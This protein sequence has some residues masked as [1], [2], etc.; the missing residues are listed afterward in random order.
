MSAT[1]FF[2]GL[3]HSCFAPKTWWTRAIHQSL[4]GQ[5]ITSMIWNSAN[6]ECA[7]LAN[8]DSREGSL[9]GFENLES[10]TDIFWCTGPLG[11][12]Q[13]DDFWDTIAKKIHANRGN[14]DCWNRMLLFLRMA[15]KFQPI[16]CF[17]EQV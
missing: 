5:S 16:S 8:F 13:Y 10:N 9:P 14:I 2:A 6:K 11:M 3:S 15:R 4:L 12:L 17:A 7:A 1:R